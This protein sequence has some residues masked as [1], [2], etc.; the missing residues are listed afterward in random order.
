M[1]CEESP[2]MPMG[3]SEKLGE[4]K[5]R[6]YCP[7]CMEC[8]VPRAKYAD[9]DGAA[10]GPSLPLMFLMTYPSFAPTSLPKYFDAKIFGFRVHARESVV[11]KRLE[12]MKE[13]RRPATV[14]RQVDSDSF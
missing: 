3:A 2:L 1:L 13:A 5:L 14:A 6:M 10:F 8:Y 9:V 4:A 11:L 7:T 12:E